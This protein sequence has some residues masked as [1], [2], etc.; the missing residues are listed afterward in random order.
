MSKPILIVGAGFTGAVLAHELA[1]SGY[2]IN[3]IDERSYLGGNCYTEKDDTGITVHVHGPHIFHTDRADVWNYVGQFADFVPYITRVKATTGGSVYGLPI[4]LHTINQY[5]G[6]TFRPDEARR[7]IAARSSPMDTPITFEDQALAFVGREL[8]E[9]FFQGY[10]IKQWGLHPRELPASVLKRLPVRF[11]YNDNYF[12][13]QYQGIPRGGYTPIFEQLLSSDSINV[14]LSTSFDKAMQAEHSH[15]F[16][17]GKLDSWFGYSHGDLGYRTLTFE[18]EVHDGDYQGCAVMSYPEEN[19][20]YTRITEHKH[21]APWETHDQ[22]II[23]REYSSLAKRSDIP[24][25]PI[26]L[27]REKDALR[28]YVDLAR[29]ETGV[30][31]VGRLGTYRYLDMDVTIG[32]AIHTANEFKRIRAEGSAVPAFFHSPL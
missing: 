16:F 22:T 15:T 10:P 31:F 24:Y 23:F 28:Q 29:S 14:Q 3:V 19:V 4:N 12:N 21:F 18:R 1:K 25:Y 6:K 7:F 30:T 5:F 32:E 20:P 13:H 9:A 11:D 27:A 2:Q 8:Y 17:S 26:R